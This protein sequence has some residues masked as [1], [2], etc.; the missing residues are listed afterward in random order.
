[1]SH[2]SARFLTLF[3]KGRISC[4]LLTRLTLPVST[5]GKPQSGTVKE[6]VTSIN[7]WENQLVNEI[8]DSRTFHTFSNFMKLKANSLH[9]NSTATGKISEPGEGSDLWNFVLQCSLMDLV[10]LVP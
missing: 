7:H 4:I 1:M 3:I 10:G 2:F 5:R 6:Q 8:A 9:I